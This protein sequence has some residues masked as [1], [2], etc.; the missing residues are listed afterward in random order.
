M[1]AST[2]L[3][4]FL[5]LF[6]AKLI[7]GAVFARIGVE[8]ISNL[9]FALLKAWRLRPNTFPNIAFVVKPNKNSNNKK[10]NDNETHNGI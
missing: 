8:K 5:H 6:F 9:R 3:P 10:R 7:Q 2:R 4:D 1:D